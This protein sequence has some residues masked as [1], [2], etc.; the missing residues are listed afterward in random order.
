MVRTGTHE[1]VRQVPI[2]HTGT[3]FECAGGCSIRGTA[4][5]LVPG[6]AIRAAALLLISVLPLLIVGFGRIPPLGIVG[7]VVAL[8]TY[9]RRRRLAGTAAHWIIELAVFVARARHAGLWSHGDR[10]LGARQLGRASSSRAAVPL[11]R[12]TSLRV[13]SREYRRAALHP[14]AL[15]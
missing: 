11:G 10:P 5:K 8:P 14:K 15:V 9:L 1:S 2:N 13:S 7:G 3:N 4:N 12:R 6:L